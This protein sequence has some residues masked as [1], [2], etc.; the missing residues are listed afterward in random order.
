MS[1]PD[2]ET[3]GAHI[4]TFGVDPSNGDVLY[5]ALR[6]GNNSL[7]KRIIYNSTT[8]G[9]PLPATLANTGAFTNVATLGAAAGRSVSPFAAVTLMCANMTK[10]EAM[11]LVGRLALP[12]LAAVAAQIVAAMVMAN[13]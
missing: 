7:I 1:Q 12:V 3:T 9:A 4:S 8:N 2:P 13:G 10:T 11:Q 6:S 5:A